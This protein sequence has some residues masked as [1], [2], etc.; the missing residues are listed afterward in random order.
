MDTQA[1]QAV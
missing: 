1:K